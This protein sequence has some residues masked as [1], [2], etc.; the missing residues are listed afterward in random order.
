MSTMKLFKVTSLIACAIVAF[1]SCKK[2]SQTKVY[3]ANKPVY[4]SYEDLRSSIKNEND[5]DLVNPGKIFLY[6]QYILINDFEAGIHVYNNSNPSSPEHIAFINIPGN[7]DIAV[8][9][10][11]LYADSYVDVVSI[12]FS[13]PKNVR[14]IDREENALSYTIPATMDYNFP[15]SEIDE[16]Q[17]VVLGYELG[18]VNEQCENDECGYMY[19]DDIAINHGEWGGSMMSDEGTVV[20]F[21]GAGNNNVR[22]V[23]NSNTQGAIAGSMARFLMVD[24]HLYVISNYETV[25]VFSASRSGLNE[26]TMFNPWHDAGNWGE[27]ETLFS[28]KDH[29]FIGST[30]G[31]LAYDVSEAGSPNY[32]SM[33]THMTACDPVV[34][35]DD[36]A[37]VTLRSGTECGLELSDQLDVLDIRNIMNPMLIGEYS[38]NQPK[39]LALDSESNLL[40]VCDG[41]FGM[42]T[43]NIENINSLQTLNTTAGDTYDVIAHNNKAHVIGNGG[44]VQYAYDADGNLSELSTISLN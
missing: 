36:F 4:L 30:T 1:S 9:D 12:D 2:V 16:T 7:V 32:L 3:T 18:E 6:N 39:G 31:M 19:Y 41:E 14:V 29:L 5:R 38:L 24:D 37:F 11:V 28:F 42:V 10:D 43:Y 15:V 26:S 35:N 33:Y 27:I 44:L 34:A 17:G 8:K 20:N 21:A 40:F 13:N 22:S 25:K 23:A